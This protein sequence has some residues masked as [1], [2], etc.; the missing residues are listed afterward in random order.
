MF[1]KEKEKGDTYLN[2]KKET[3]TS[4][5]K[6]VQINKDAIN[7]KETRLRDLQNKLNALYILIICEKL[8]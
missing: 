5:R 1:Y 6:G 7:E 8:N 3:I 2:Q 4:L